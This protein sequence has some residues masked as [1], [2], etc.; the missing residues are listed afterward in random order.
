MIMRKSADFDQRKRV[1]EKSEIIDHCFKSQPPTP[2]PPRPQQAWLG[3]LV[4]V[5]AICN[6][7]GRDGHARWSTKSAVSRW[8]RALPELFIPGGA[9]WTHS[10]DYELFLGSP[11]CLKLGLC[12]SGCVRG[13][14]VKFTQREPG[15]R[16]QSDTESGQLPLAEL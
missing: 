2:P 10:R 12:V 13:A 8:P 16:K 15:V 5:R 3:G 14:G 11:C 6:R 1:R 7:Q 4:D 9:L